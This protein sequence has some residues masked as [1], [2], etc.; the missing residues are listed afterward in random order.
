MFRG[1]ILCLL[2]AV[3]LLPGTA[4]AD[5]SP[6]EPNV[7]AYCTANNDFSPVFSSHGECVT[8]FH[9]D[10]MTFLAVYCR[11]PI[12]QQF[13]ETDNVGQCVKVFRSSLPKPPR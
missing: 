13:T 3:F 8:A 11:D 2:A 12:N 5:P 10:D 1:L 7:S 6:V 9:R 4:N